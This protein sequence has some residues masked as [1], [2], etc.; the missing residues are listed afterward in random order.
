MAGP[1]FDGERRHRHRPA[2]VRDRVLGFV[3]FEVASF[4]VLARLATGDSR[5]AAALPADSAGR[6]WLMRW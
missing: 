6:S 4:G 1:A 5:P 3:A 2:D